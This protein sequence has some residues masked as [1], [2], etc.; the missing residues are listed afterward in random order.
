MPGLHG[1]S[2][3]ASAD[4]RRL[5]KASVPQPDSRDASSSTARRDVRQRVT[6]CEVGQRE[7]RACQVR[8]PCTGCDSLAARAARVAEVAR[9]RGRAVRLTAS[10][11]LSPRS[12]RRRLPSRQ[13]PRLCPPPPSAA[14]PQPPRAGGERAAKIDC[15]NYFG[16]PP[17]APISNQ[18]P[19]PVSLLARPFPAT[20]RSKQHGRATGLLVEQLPCSGLTPLVGSRRGNRTRPA[21]HR[22]PSRTLSL[23]ASVLV[24]RLAFFRERIESG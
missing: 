1:T 6:A 17:G 3:R 24:R 19:H 11:R 18:G 5:R 7:R 20:P 10:R 2:R 22:A 13:P 16:P 15:S 12:R 23:G 21:S 14:P 4:G 9:A 8:H